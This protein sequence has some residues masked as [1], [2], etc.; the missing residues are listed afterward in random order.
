MEDVASIDNRGISFIHSLV[1]SLVCG[2]LLEVKF[3]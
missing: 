1:H 2:T 3:D